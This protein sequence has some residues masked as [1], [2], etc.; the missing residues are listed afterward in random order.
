MV[1]QSRETL[2]SLFAELTDWEEQLKHTNIEHIPDF[3]GPQ[4]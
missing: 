1:P 3:E 4:P 2:N